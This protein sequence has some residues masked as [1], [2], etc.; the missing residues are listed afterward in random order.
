MAR[1]RD[2]K[3]VRKPTAQMRAFNSG[4]EKGSVASTFT[5]EQQRAFRD[6]LKKH[7]A[8]ARVM[9]RQLMQ[10]TMRSER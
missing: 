6:W 9:E 10:G 2:P 3:L 7:Q 5:K 1:N 8:D 4:Y